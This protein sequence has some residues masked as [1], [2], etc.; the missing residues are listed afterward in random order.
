M[1]PSFLINDRAVH[2][3][4]HDDQVIQHMPHGCRD[5]HLTVSWRM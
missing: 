2:T 5:S 4:Q 1:H 3:A